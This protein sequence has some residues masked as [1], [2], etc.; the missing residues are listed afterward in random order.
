M[1]QRFPGGLPPKEE[2]DDRGDEQDEERE[3][4]DREDG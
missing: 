2:A 4:A 1:D 3:P